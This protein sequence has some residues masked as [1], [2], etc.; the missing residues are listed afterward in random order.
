MNNRR[1]EPKSQGCNNKVLK[2]QCNKELQIFAVF[3]E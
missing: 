3:I 2:K 1:K